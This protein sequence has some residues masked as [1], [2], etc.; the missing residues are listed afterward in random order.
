[1]TV[2]WIKDKSDV[3][4]GFYYCLICGNLHKLGEDCDSLIYDKKVKK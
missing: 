2:P 1:M 3:P 4:E